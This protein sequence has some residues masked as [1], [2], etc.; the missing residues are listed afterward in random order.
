MIYLRFHMLLALICADKYV[1]R[2]D[3]KEKSKNPV[4]EN[5][6]EV[7]TR[8]TT[9]IDSNES[10]LS[11]ASTIYP[12]NGGNPSYPTLSGRSSWTSSMNLKI[13][14]RTIHGSLRNSQFIYW[15]Q[16]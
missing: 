10:T 15:F 2:H 6:D 3:I 7:I 11:M 13:P 12:F 8:G 1:N 4:S 16:S 5:R 9:L 14:F